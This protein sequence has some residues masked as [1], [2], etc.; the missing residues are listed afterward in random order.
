LIHKLS[1]IERQKA[2]ETLIFLTEK[3]DETTKVRTCA[4]GST[5]QKYTGH[6][7]ATIP[8][9]LTK[10]HSI[11]TV[12]DAKQHQDVITANIPNAFVQTDMINKINNKRTIVE[13]FDRPIYFSPKII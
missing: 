5:Q 6:D 10:L 1:S 8:T 9:A 7:K 12:I 13:R 11:S 3:N 2:I 4:N